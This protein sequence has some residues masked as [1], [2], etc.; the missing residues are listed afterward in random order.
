MITKKINFKRNKK[1]GQYIIGVISCLAIIFPILSIN[2]CTIFKNEC[3]ICQK[4]IPW[5]KSIYTY[6]QIKE[7][8]VSQFK[9]LHYNSINYVFVTTDDKKLDLTTDNYNIRY[10]G[11]VEDKINDTIPHVITSD[12]YSNFTEDIDKIARWK[13]IKQ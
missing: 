9:G 13:V 10:I 11:K 6:D 8:R 7:V 5:R 4:E 3:I 1:K 2:K 12:A